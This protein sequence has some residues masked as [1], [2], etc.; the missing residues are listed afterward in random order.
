MGLQPA[1]HRRAAPATPRPIHPE[2][3]SWRTSRIGWGAA[4]VPA[5][6][7]L[8]AGVVA[9]VTT[10]VLWPAWWAPARQP[11]WCPGRTGLRMPRPSRAGRAAPQP[12]GT[13][14]K[15]APW[16][17][18]W[19]CHGVPSSSSGGRRRPACEEGLGACRGIGLAPA[20]P[21]WTSSPPQRGWL[22]GWR[23]RSRP[24][25]LGPW[26]CAASRSAP[27]RASGAGPATCRRGGRRAWSE[28]RR[29]PPRGQA[30]GDASR[31]RSCW[32]GRP[33]PPPLLR[34]GRPGPSA[35]SRSEA[36]GSGGTR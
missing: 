12:D 7:L 15:A 17:V 30:G 3:V 4:L 35:T 9:G 11:A 20:T 22:S 33:Q 26:S 18:G 2:Q 29:M 16:V 27:V 23:P 21:E 25:R 5:V 28:A 19:P 32:L 13:P 34:A 6:D 14:G 36:T 24:M 1:L 8:G 10:V 31:R